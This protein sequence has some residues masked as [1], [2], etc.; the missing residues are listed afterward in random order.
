M[1]TKHSKPTLRARLQTM[2]LL[3]DREAARMPDYVRE[4]DRLALMEALQAGWRQI[5]RI[6]ARAAVAGLLEERGRRQAG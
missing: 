4:R 2:A 1:N 6:K 3:L 5:M